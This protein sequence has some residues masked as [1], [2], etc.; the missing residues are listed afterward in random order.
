M[1][2][3]NIVDG[4][5]ASEYSSEEYDNIIA[6]DWQS[7]TRDIP[8]S[9]W[10]EMAQSAIAEGITQLNVSWLEG[11]E[12]TERLCDRALADLAIGKKVAASQ[13]HV[14]QEVLKITN[15]YRHCANGGWWASG[16]DPLSDWQPMQWGCFKPKSPWTSK[17]TGKIAKY[18]HPEKEST[19]AFFPRI[20]DDIWLQFSV[21]LGIPIG[22]SKSFWEWVAANSIP[23]WITEGY[24]KTASLLSNGVIAIGLSGISSGYRNKEGVRSLIPDLQWL[25]NREIVIAFD[26]DV[27]PTTRHNTLVASQNLGRLFSKQGCKVSIANWGEYPEKGIDDLIFNHG[28]EILTK[29]SLDPLQIKPNYDSLRDADW[30]INKRYLPTELA[31]QSNRLLA[32]KSP[33]GTGKTE[34]FSHLSSR[35]QM[36]DYKVIVV[37]HRCQLA[38]ALGH[39]LGVSY[40]DDLSGVNHNGFSIVIDSLHPNG[41]GEIDVANDYRY[42]DCKYVVILDE[43]EQLL[44]HLMDSKTEVSRHRTAILQQFQLLL[45]NAD[46]IAIADAD[47]SNISLNY[48]EKMV[49]GDDKP[50]T[51]LVENNYQ[52]GAY[53]CEVFEDP[54]PSRLLEEMVRDAATQK[55]IVATDAQKLSSK[56][57]TKV[58]E[59]LLKQHYPEKKILR[60]DSESIADPD[61]PAFGAISKDINKLIQ[62]FDILIFSPSMGTGVSI[63]VRGHFDVCYGFFQGVQQSSSCRQMLLRLRDNIPRKIWVAKR[64]LGR[65]GNGSFYPKQLLSATDKQLAI[66]L[67]ILIGAGMGDAEDTMP[68]VDSSH[69]SVYAQMACRINV[70]TSDYRENLISG[71]KAEGVKVEVSQGKSDFQKEVVVPLAED[72]HQK[73]CEDT[74]ASQIEDLIE[75]PEKGDALLNRREKTGYERSRA[76]KFLLHKLYGGIREISP[77]MV[78]ATSKP[79]YHRAVTLHYYLNRDEKALERDIERYQKY[80]E[81]NQAIFSPDLSQSLLSAKIKV[82]QTLKLPEMLAYAQLH[83]DMP[84]VSEINQIASQFK[85]DVETFLGKWDAANPMAIV[86]KLIRTIG[87]EL[88]NVGRITSNGKQIRVFGISLDSTR[89]QIFDAWDIVPE[90]VPETDDIRAIVPNRS[91]LWQIVEYKNRGAVFLTKL[92]QGITSIWKEASRIEFVSV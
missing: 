85:G 50:D 87:G 40:I 1:T 55:L 64:G 39:R 9:V 38:V 29:I 17:K 81:N 11:D 73:Q 69:L 12:P 63:D 88:T 92:V 76:S 48:V 19:R 10:N 47:L 21:S 90:T 43:I 60:I 25:E 61:N 66:N 70:D 33:K 7:E 84:I 68:I 37:S 67:S 24:K 79:G 28:R 58:I 78:H 44:W 22:D 80:K 51:L 23:I 31:Q 27:K 8:Q 75:S 57:S 86:R 16:V 5:R 89:Y 52:D 71:L 34:I 20:P 72:L 74:A 4:V 41:K 54:N 30:K 83:R 3:N 35:L 65:I 18:Q 26:N 46:M 62:S 36:D 53:E 13:Q 42:L 45:E 14:T 82:L 56:T 2:H 6:Y 49:F 77:E 59:A 91:G 15:K 32:I